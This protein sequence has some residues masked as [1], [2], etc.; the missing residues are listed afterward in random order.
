MKRLTIKRVNKEL[1]KYDAELVKGNGYFWFFTKDNLKESGVYV[2]RLNALTLG[3]WI[4]ELK[5]KRKD[6]D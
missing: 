4:N 3:G 6:N 5:D 2:N 1:E